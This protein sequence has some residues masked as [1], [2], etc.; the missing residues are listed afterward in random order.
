MDVKDRIGPPQPETTTGFPPTDQPSA[1][2]QQGQAIPA[3]PASPAS[4]GAGYGPQY[5][6]PA[7]G[8]L[9]YAPP[10]KRENWLVAFWNKGFWHKIVLALGILVIAFVLLRLA[11]GSGAGTAS[12]PTTEPQAQ[13]T[14]V[15]THTATSAPV[16]TNHK[17]GDQVKVNSTWTA[18]INSAT[19]TQGDGTFPPKVGNTYLVIDLTLKNTSAQ[20]QT[21]SSLVDFALKDATGQK[22][23]ESITSGTGTSPDGTVEAGGLLRG[24]LVYEVPQAQ[25]HFVF[26]FQPDFTSTDQ[27]LWDITR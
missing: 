4:P 15:A 1:P 11:T 16:V 3:M 10:T 20:A 27:T 9:A 8:P 2:D 13:A 17:V 12:P 14:H 18:T 26:A 5:G 7:Y 19:A 24:Q 22:Y 23:D 25:Q 6:P 21:V